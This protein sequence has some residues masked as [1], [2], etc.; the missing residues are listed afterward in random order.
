MYHSHFL[1]FLGILLCGTLSF[2]DYQYKKEMIGYWQ[3]QQTEN[4]VSIG[5]TDVFHYDGEY[6]TIYM[7]AMKAWMWRT[8][9]DLYK[10]KTKIVGNELHYLPPFGNWEAFIKFE[11][12]QFHSLHNNDVYQKISVEQLSTEAQVFLNPREVHDYNIQATDTPKWIKNE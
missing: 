11:N 10:V 12:G 2:N 5:V 8:E 3:I 4:E 9:D 7:F 6:L 1:A